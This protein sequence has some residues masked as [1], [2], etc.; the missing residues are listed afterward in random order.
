MFLFDQNFVRHGLTSTESF[1]MICRYNFLK[2]KYV[3]KK[4]GIRLQIMYTY[5]YISNIIY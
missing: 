4:L 3:I 5:T 1:K 2:F